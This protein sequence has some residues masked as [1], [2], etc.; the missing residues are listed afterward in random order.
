[1]R[2]TKNRNRARKE[3]ISTQRASYPAAQ[4]TWASQARNRLAY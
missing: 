1:M 4:V 2:R 3:I